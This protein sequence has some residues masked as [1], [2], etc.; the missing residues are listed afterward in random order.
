VLK[1]V[2]KIG[3]WLLVALG[4]VHTSLTPMFY[5]RLSVGAM[6]FAG[7]GLAMI[8]VG[9]LNIALSRGAGSDGLVRILC[10]TA[11]LMTSVFGVMIVVV[12]YEPQVI[13]GLVLIFLMTLT[14]LLL[15]K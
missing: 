5:G 7:S 4:V 1:T 9:F 11:N 8:F 6:W 13:F 3:S 15:K 14:A 2:H 10:H 12:N